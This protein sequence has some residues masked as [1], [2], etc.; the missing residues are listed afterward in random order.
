MIYF[1]DFSAGGS[2]SLSD[3]VKLYLKFEGANGGTTITDSSNYARSITNVGVVTSTAW[4]SE[5]SSSGLFADDGDHLELADSDDWALGTN[6]F[7]IAAWINVAS[8]QFPKII[9]QRG[10]SGDLMSLGHN[11]SNAT[12]FFMST[13]AGQVSLLGKTAGT[14]I[15]H[16]AISRNASGK[17]RLRV[18]GVVEA[19]V[20]ETA[21]SINIAR[22][23]WIGRNEEPAGSL[24]LQFYGSM[25]ELYFING[26][27]L[28][29]TDSAALIPANLAGSAGFSVRPAI[30]DA[31]GR[32]VGNVLTCSSG[33]CWGSG[34]Y[35]Y[36]W[37]MS[38]V[39]IS[40]ATSANYTIQSGD[41]LSALS[42]VV[43][44]G[45]NSYE[46]R[47][48][49]RYWRVY[50]TATNGSGFVGVSDIKM[51]ADVN[52][53]PDTGPD[54]TTIF[55]TEY[56]TGN[57][58]AANAFDNDPTAGPCW[59]SSGAALPQWIGQDIPDTRPHV[60]RVTIR[61]RSSADAAQA[62]KDFAIQYSDDG[63][64][65][66]TAW[67]VTNQTGWGDYETRTFNRP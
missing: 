43:T 16:V 23:M 31:A 52:A 60:M 33:Y 53:G 61:S 56:S 62:P 3:D 28:F 48:G 14:G 36:Q 26:T 67:S 13:T 54:K 27:D 55:S 44:H 6:P 11:D 49:H 63:S 42:C 65:W 51:M 64:S 19:S 17:I 29:D 57:E 22:P 45:T 12:Q 50:V 41:D 18:N 58:K 46:T 25:D 24:S 8:F 34:S 2:P 5:G 4:A 32:S 37:K 59:A 38:G 47:L 9:G 30:S 20:V 21:A 15:R 39:V 35:S 7:T 10:G 1:S 66:T 40:G